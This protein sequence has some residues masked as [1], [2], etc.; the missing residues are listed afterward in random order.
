MDPIIESGIS[1][2]NDYV[3]AELLVLDGD[4]RLRPTHAC[5]TRLNFYEPP[6]LVSETIEIV[7]TNGDEQD[8]HLATVLPHDADA[9]EIPIQLLKML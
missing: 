6:R 4:R 5:A 8:R 1:R 9:S 3:Y 2:A 7:L